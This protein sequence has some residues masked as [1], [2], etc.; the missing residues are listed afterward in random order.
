M[1]ETVAA[2]EKKN[3]AGKTPVQPVLPRPDPAR[4]ISKKT[5][6]INGHSPKPVLQ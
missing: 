2:G 6:H 5:N 1:R 4:Q 3:R